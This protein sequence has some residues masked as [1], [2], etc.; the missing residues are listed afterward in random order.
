MNVKGY[1]LEDDL[2]SEL[3]KFAVLWNLFEKDF[4]NYNCTPT[5]INDLLGKISI[6][7]ENQEI[8]KEALN[9][10][11]EIGVEIIGIYDY[12]ESGL[13]PENAHRSTP[14]NIKR[15]KDFME[16]NGN[17]IGCLLIVERI[18]NNLMHGLKIVCQLN[19]QI[20]LFKAVNSVLESIEWF[21]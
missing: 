12:I 19:E 18:R 20:D 1:E 9:S 10:R 3:G 6:K 15:M 8:L 4:C 17:E 7:K 21:Y 14:E 5:K 11:R 2:I 16:G 13:H